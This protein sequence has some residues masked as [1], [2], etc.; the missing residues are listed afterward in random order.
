MQDLQ[1]TGISGVNLRRGSVNKIWRT[2][3]VSVKKNLRNGQENPRS[4]KEVKKETTGKRESLENWRKYGNRKKSR[5]L[6]KPVKPEKVRGVRIKEEKSRR[7]EESRKAEKSR[8][9]E[10]KHSKKSSSSL[11]SKSRPSGKSSTKELDLRELLKK[12]RQLQRLEEEA[13]SDDDDGDSDD[14]ESSDEDSDSEDS[15]SSDSSSSS[16]DKR[17]KKKKYIKAKRGKTNLLVEMKGAILGVLDK[18]I[19]SLGRK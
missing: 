8:M 15:S 1:V 3:S 10:R 4:L 11:Q 14:S 5:K 19:S 17:K 2:G 9:V 7:V 18:E 12:K 16:A 6:E 13:S